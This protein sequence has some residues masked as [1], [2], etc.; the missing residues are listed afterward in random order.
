MDTQRSVTPALA[1]LLS[2]ALIAAG[3]GGGR[4][5]AAS[6][7]TFSGRATVLSG[8]VAG[9]PVNLVDTGPVDAGGGHLHASVL[10]YP[11]DLPDATNGAFTA[12]VL[13][14][15][16]VAHGNKSSAEAVVANFSLNAA[17]QSIQAEFL[18]ARASATCNS[19]SAAITASSEIVGLNVNGTQVVVGN[20]P[21]TITLPLGAGSIA[22]HEEPVASASGDSGNVTV[23]ALHIVLVG[24]TDVVVASAHADITC[25][26]A[27]G[28]CANGQDFVTGGGWIT[29]KS[30]SRATFAVAGGPG[31]W[32]HFQYIDHGSGLKIK[33]TGV[34]LY[35]PGT[36]GPTSRQIDGTAQWT[37]GGGTYSVD[38]AD[39]GEPGHGMDIFQINAPAVEKAT[40]GGG[41]IQLHCN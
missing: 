21:Q 15:T 25:A 33:G 10:E 5:A 26:A 37:G 2:F 24:G 13:H 28:R 11:G 29:T 3:S 36:N 17:G 30:G 41:N 38:V 31:G 27:A 16:V 22:I 14:A 20:Q 40:L 18:A 6:A 9:L 19:G 8:T 23:N 12:E 1:L 4:A 32:G 35:R 34:T 39:N 7:T